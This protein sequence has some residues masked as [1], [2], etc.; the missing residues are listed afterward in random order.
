MQHVTAFNA[1]DV[2]GMGKMQHPEI[3]WLSV[4]GNMVSVEVNGRNELA[5]N[6]TEYFNSPT[7]VTGTLRD[8]SINPPYVSVTETA[9]WTATDGTKK[10]QSSLTV[11]ELEN[12]LIR[13]V[14]YYPAVDD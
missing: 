9:S 1:G 8:W 12:N 4:K 3:Q 7:K 6:M 10:S 5:R 14:W 13:R 11:Y 2:D